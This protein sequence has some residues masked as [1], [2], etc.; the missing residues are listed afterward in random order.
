M[1]RAITAIICGIFFLAGHENF[2]QRAVF[3]E[4]ESD[5]KFSRDATAAGYC[6]TNTFERVNSSCHQGGTVLYFRVL[7]CILGY[8]I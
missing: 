7:Y 1:F 2:E 4:R 3:S 5:Q 6:K 8:N